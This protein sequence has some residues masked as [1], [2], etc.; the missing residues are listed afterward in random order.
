[1]TEGETLFNRFLQG[2]KT[3]HGWNREVTQSMASYRPLYLA[4]DGQT[5][6]YEGKFTWIPG[7]SS[8][9]LSNV[10][11]QL[12]WFATPGA[13]RE[14]NDKGVVS[15]LAGDVLYTNLFP[16]VRNNKETLPEA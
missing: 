14:I 8:L 13:P 15:V 16:F 12:L 6:L 1:S 9:P 11:K 4:L 10:D 5:P 2:D 7:Q 3:A